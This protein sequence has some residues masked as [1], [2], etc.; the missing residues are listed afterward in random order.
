MFEVFSLMRIH[1]RCVFNDVQLYSGAPFNG[2][3]LNGAQFN[4]APHFM[5]RHL[6]VRYLMV[7]ARARDAAAHAGGDCGRDLRHPHG[8]LRDGPP[9]P[10][11]PRSRLQLLFL[12]V[13]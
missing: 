11:G 5:V 10:R 4:G 9:A 2:V 1:I 13:F 12:E 7:R 8:L 3:S 6:I